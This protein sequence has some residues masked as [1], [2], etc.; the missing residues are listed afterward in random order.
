VAGLLAVRVAALCSLRASRA[1]AR[2]RLALVLFLVEM[3]TPA[4]WSSRTADLRSFVEVYLM[5]VIVLLGRPCQPRKRALR[6][7]AA[8]LLPVATAGLLP[9][10]GYILQRRV[11]WS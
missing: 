9:V 2:E 7:R 10:L 3:V 11:H 6:S 8:W 1:P 5:A 4:T